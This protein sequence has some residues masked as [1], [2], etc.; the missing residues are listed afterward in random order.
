MTI[1]LRNATEEN[2]LIRYLA[3]RDAP[4]QTM[5]FGVLPNCKKALVEYD[6][7]V[8]LLTGDMAKFSEYNEA[9][10]MEIKFYVGILRPAL[11]TI[12]STMEEQEEPKP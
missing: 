1:S 9:V 10:A 5:Q 7:F 11:E 6:A 2:E 12:I 4:R 8:T 3:A